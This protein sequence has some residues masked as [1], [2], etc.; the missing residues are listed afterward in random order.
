[1][2]IEMFNIW[3]FFWLFISIG[4]FVGIYFLLKNKSDKTKQI[5]LFSLLAFAL[6]LHFLKVLFPPYSTD[7]NRLYR[8]IWFVNICGANIALFPFIFL[9]KNKYLKDYMFYLGIL[10]GFISV[11]Y[12]MEPMLKSN[13]SGELLDII[14]FYIH[15]NI[16]WYVPLLM[17][18]FKLHK[19]DYKRILA[20]PICF[21]SVMIFIMI[22]Q[23]LQSE[24]G[25]IALRDSN[26]FDINYKNSSMIWA[27]SGSIGKF[28]AT[29]CPDIFKS[30]PVGPY[31]TQE[32][33]WPLIWLVCPM[34]ILL[35]PVSFLMCLVFE[36]QHFIS[37][38]KSNIKQIKNI[39]N[40]NKIGTEHEKNKF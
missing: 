25:Y 29:F 27:P 10:G 20:V 30:V 14:R 32:K 16:L 6:I 28:L 1:M 13:Q 4:C 21:I 22:N 26:F 17:V 3:Y 9:S 40:K 39:I 34:Y 7:I 5:V 18:M 31:A 2:E 35:V 12:P 19:L 15:H 36:N 33:Y 23:I 11:I 24:L 38:C 8:D 37:D